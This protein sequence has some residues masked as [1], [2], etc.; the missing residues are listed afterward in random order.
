MRRSSYKVLLGLFLAVLTLAGLSQT[1]T[2]QTIVRQWRIG[3]SNHQGRVKI[4]DGSNQWCNLESPALS[5]DVTITMP[6]ATCTLSSSAAALTSGSV[7]YAGAGG[8]LT[9][10]TVN[11]LWDATANSNE[12]TLGS[13][14]AAGQLKFLE[15]S[16]GGVNFY[17]IKAPATLAGNLTLTLPSATMADTAVPFMSA[18]DT[19]SSDSA[20]FAFDDTANSNELK[21]GSGTA[22]G[23]IQFLE[24]SGGGTDKACI[25]SPAALSADYTL[26]LPAD[27]GV[28]YQFLQT[29]GAGAL[30]FADPFIWTSNT[31]DFTGAD[32]DTAQPVFA[33]ANDTVTLPANTTFLLEASYRIKTTGTSAHTLALLFGGTATLTSIAYQAQSTNSATDILTQDSVIWSEVATATVVTSSASSA[34][35]HSIT[36]RGMVRTNGTGTFIPQYQW[37]AAPGV[38]GVVEAN[39]W[40]KLTPLGVDTKAQAGGW[41]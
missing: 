22:A 5:A 18:A 3:D 27:D 7:P 21:L 16:G 26:T 34:T 38:A 17:G 41:S 24:G 36:I 40:L 8:V 35:H 15:G 1:A 29:D 4:S 32:V 12:L 9:E 11:L 39:S 19:L 31:T 37:S 25:K 13:G 14:T 10:D 33:A 2:G 30:T 28:A 6:S 23:Q 20:N